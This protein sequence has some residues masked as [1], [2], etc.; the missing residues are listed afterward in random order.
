VIE[1]SDSRGA[2]QRLVQ[3]GA[4]AIS[5]LVYCISCVTMKIAFVKQ[6]MLTLLTEFG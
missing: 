2:H 1:L 3:A 4:V 6:K 5:Y